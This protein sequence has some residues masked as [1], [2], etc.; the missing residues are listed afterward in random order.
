MH[1]IIG[2]RAQG[3]LEYALK[4]S[5]E[6]AIVADLNSV[7]LQ[8]T[9]DADVIC[10]IHLGVRKQIE[11][12]LEPLEEF[13]RFIEQLGDVILI[14]DE[15]GSGIVPV[16]TFERKWRDETGRVYVMLTKNA[17]KVDRIWAGCVQNLKG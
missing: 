17:D 5:K 4:I 3:K 7:S 15:I 9:A 8:E 1:L 12:G 6:N 16:D 11:A 2:G 10:N 14:G 13:N